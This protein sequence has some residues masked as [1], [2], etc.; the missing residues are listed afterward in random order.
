MKTDLDFSLK[1]SL[2]FTETTSLLRTK[3]ES[4]VFNKISITI[5]SKR[6][7]EVRLV[8]YFVALDVDRCNICSI[9]LWN[10]ADAFSMLPLVDVNKLN[11]WSIEWMEA[12][13]AFSKSYWHRN[14]KLLFFFRIFIQTSQTMNYSC[15]RKYHRAFQCNDG[16]RDLFEQIW[17]CGCGVARNKRG[18]QIC[19][20]QDV[21][22][23]KK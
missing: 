6:V 23:I 3:M 4:D 11:E 7:A 2:T 22:I 1:W 18:C 8:L 17:A 13:Y 15:R 16:W 9:W 20:N 5:S 21:M 19:V 10:Y 12:R 14:K